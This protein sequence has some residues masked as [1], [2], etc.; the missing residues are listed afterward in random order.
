MFRVAQRSSGTLASAET[1][2]V[3]ADNKNI[4]YIQRVDAPQWANVVRRICASGHIPVVPGRIYAFERP[5]WENWDATGDP[6][7]DF[8]ATVQL[9]LGDPATA[10]PLNTPPRSHTPSSHAQRSFRSPK[11]TSTQTPC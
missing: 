2:S 6:P 1:V 4:G 7:K 10:L 3:R 11:K 9:K 5:D 8:G